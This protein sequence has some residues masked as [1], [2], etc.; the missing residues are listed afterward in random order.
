M[1]A[2]ARRFGTMVL[3][4]AAPLSWAAEEAPVTEAP[5]EFVVAEFIEADHNQDGYID[6]E[7]ADAIPG[8][9]GVFML[10]DQDQDGGITIEEYSAIRD[11]AAPNDGASIDAPS[12]GYAR[13]AAVG[14]LSPSIF[15]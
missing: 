12:E 11:H 15:G 4:M 3:V 13:W 2:L 14:Q 1:K 5:P 9:G 8:L 6:I 10:V 7:E